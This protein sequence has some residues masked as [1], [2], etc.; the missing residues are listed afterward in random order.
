M[1]QQVQCTAVMLLETRVGRR[2]LTNIPLRLARVLV[3]NDC[4]PVDGAASVKV[5]LELLRCR[6]VIHLHKQVG[7]DAVC[8]T[9]A[10]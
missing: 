6:R 7:T 2:N 8:N 9:S 10:Q 1:T 4:H 5:L 3:A